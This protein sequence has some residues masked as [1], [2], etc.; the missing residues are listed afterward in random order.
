VIFGKA[1]LIVVS[2]AGQKNVRQKDNASY[3]SVLHF[4]VRL[5]SVA[6]TTIKAG[7]ETSFVI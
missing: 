4:S 7:K 2:S 6:E 5:D 1:A 3:F